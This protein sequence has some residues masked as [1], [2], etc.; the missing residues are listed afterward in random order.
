MIPEG[1]ML[2]PTMCGFETLSGLS[3]NKRPLKEGKK[4]I[5]GHEEGVC[6][7][8]NVVWIPYENKDNISLIL[9]ESLPQMKLHENEDYLIS[10]N[11]M[12]SD[13]PFSS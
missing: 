10:F 5:E 12:K 8:R 4:L 7:L 2:N 1:K 6:H 13:K 9:A 3:F 11:V